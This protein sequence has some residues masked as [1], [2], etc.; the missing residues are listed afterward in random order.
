MSWNK[1]KFKKV[2]G[3]RERKMAQ[4][5]RKIGGFSG[6]K[7]CKAPIKKSFRLRSL[8]PQASGQICFDIIVQCF[9]FEIP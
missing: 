2:R 8:V 4:K 1:K 3:A 9:C 5:M 7:N 6:Q